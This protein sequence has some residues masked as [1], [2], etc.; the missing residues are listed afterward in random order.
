MIISDN[1]SIEVGV[2]SLESRR[3]FRLG[4]TVELVAPSILVED[5]QPDSIKVVS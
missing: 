3:L 5:S 2:E 4:V 1:H